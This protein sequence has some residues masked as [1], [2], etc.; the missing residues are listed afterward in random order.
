MNH[1]IRNLTL[2]S[3]TFLVAFSV[4][5]GTGAHPTDLGLAV[6]RPL[7]T[8]EVVSKRPKIVAFGDSL[9]AGFG[10]TERESYPYLLQERLNADGYNYEVLNA[11]VSGD[12]SLGG[13]ERV[14]WVLEQDGVEILILEL[15]ANDLLRGVP[16]AKMKTNLDQIISKAEKKN[17][18]VLLCGML[19]PPAMGAEYQ[20][21]YSSAFPDLA[22]EHHVAYLPFLLEN[23]ALKRDLNQ[24]DG[25][26][27]NGEGTKIMMANVYKELKPM[28]KI[29]QF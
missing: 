7:K 2:L 14:D 16:V 9:T 10:L 21:A 25:I 19:A 26:H 18:A 17:V 29:K 20:R 5:C 22:N 11:G 15:G 12:T 8:P 6:N 1:I 3:F 28:L 13:V 27:P 4:G 23:I 24:A